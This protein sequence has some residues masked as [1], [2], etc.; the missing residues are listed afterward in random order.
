MIGDTRKLSGIPPD[1]VPMFIHPSV[2][3]SFSLPH[4]WSVAVRAVNF[5][6]TLERK[7]TGWTSLCTLINLFN[8]LKQVKANLQKEMSLKNWMNLLEMK[9]TYGIVK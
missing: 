8:L 1:V 7:E 9:E 3:S 6:D 5:I 4:I 2:Q